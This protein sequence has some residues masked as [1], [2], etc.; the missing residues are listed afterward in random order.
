MTKDKTQRQ[1]L[2]IKSRHGMT[3][4]NSY[5]TASH[6]TRGRPQSWNLYGTGSR[7]LMMNLDA[8]HPKRW[9]STTC[10]CFLLHVHAAKGPSYGM[11]CIQVNETT[12]PDLQHGQAK[13]VNKRMPKVQ[14]LFSFVDWDIKRSA[15]F[16]LPVRIECKNKKS[17]SRSRSRSQDRPQG[18]SQS[19]VAGQD[20]IRRCRK[21]K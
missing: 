18:S 16:G 9:I 19:S 7:F 10:I 21:S 11:E 3:S 20:S 6:Q 13:I 12:G 17:K 4:Y 8:L 14:C 2:D 1:N 15:S 5:N